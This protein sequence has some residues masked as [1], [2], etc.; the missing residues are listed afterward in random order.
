MKNYRRAKGEYG[1]GHILVGV[2]Q[3]YLS[4]AGAGKSKC[5]RA[6]KDER[7]TLNDERKHSTE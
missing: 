5:G 7:G 1:A 2:K 3:D 4:I 6:I